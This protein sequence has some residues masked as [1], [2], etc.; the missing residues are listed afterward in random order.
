MVGVDGGGTSTRA[1]VLDDS[2]AEIARVEREGAVVTVGGSA[3]RQ[4]L[5]SRQPSVI[6]AEQGGVTLPVT[7][8]V[9]WD[10]R[11]RVEKRPVMR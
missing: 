3:V 8:A 10:S 11:G 5:R 4:R 7:S 1:V 2:G 6:A 9:G